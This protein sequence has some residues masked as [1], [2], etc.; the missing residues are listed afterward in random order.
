MEI[1]S[2]ETFIPNFQATR[3]HLAFLITLNLWKAT[4]RVGE[5]N[6]WT[7]FGVTILT[8][9]TRQISFRCEIFLQLWSKDVDM[10]TCDHERSI[11]D[12][13][14]K[15]GTNL[16]F[17]FVFITLCYYLKIDNH[18]QVQLANSSWFSVHRKSFLSNLNFKPMM[19]LII[20]MEFFYKVQ[21]SLCCIV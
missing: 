13:I 10:L 2:R 3:L 15:A 17:N 18:I 7:K 12:I 20:A 6:N 16:E 11:F 8:L 21:I 9:H 5:R 14:G 19:C 4:F 1:L